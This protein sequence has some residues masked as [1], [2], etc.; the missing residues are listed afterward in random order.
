MHENFCQSIKKQGKF[1]ITT[2]I[3]YNIENAAPNENNFLCLW[4]IPHRWRKLD[5]LKCAV[6]PQLGNK[7]ENISICGGHYAKQVKIMRHKCRKLLDVHK[8]T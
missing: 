6:N 1:A 5:M 7:G 4:L 8:S 3:N 2:E